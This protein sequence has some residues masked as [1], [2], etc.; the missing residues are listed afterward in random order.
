MTDEEWEA[1]FVGP[2][3]AKPDRE[4]WLHVD[5]DFEFEYDSP[6]RDNTPTL[7]VAV[8]GKNEY[9]RT[10]SIVFCDDP[11]RIHHTV[12]PHGAGWRKI[13]G[14]SETNHSVWMRERVRGNLMIG[15]RGSVA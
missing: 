5:G 4:Y 2:W 9:T 3:P 6:P 15:P 10:Y 13:W 11:D 8:K 7:H 14:D 12:G 1:R